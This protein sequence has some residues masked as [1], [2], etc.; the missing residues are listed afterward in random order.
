MAQLAACKSH[1]L[2]VVSSNLTGQKILLFR[3]VCRYCLF[4]GEK[5][6][7]KTR[8]LENIKQKRLFGE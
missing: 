8:F 2:K 6:V 7:Q 1:K 3:V 5:K 4:Q